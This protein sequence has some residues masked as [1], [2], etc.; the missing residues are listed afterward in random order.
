MLTIPNSAQL[1]LAPLVM[2]L[3]FTISGGAY[4]LEDLVSKSGPGMALVLIVLLTL[5]FLTPLLYHLPQA[6]LAAIIIMAVIG[7]EI[8]R[9]HV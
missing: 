3:F 4:G 6:V 7:L 1:K 8:G 9:A 5:L 2:V